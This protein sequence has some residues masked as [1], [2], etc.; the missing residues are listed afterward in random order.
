MLGLSQAWGHRVSAVAVGGLLAGMAVAAGDDRA[1]DESRTERTGCQDEFRLVSSGADDDVAGHYHQVAD[2]FYR[3]GGLGDEFGYAKPPMI[4]RM[5]PSNMLTILAAIGHYPLPTW[6]SAME[7]IRNI[8]GRSGV[9]EFV[10]SGSFCVAC[11]SHATGRTMQESIF[12]HVFGHNSFGSNSRVRR[13]IDHSPMHDSYSLG[14][15]MDQLYQ[16][17]DGG[18]VDAWYAALSTLQHG[19]DSIRG[20]HQGP[21]FFDQRTR[22]QEGRRLAWPAFP[23]RSLLAFGV[24]ALPASTPEWKRGMARRFE[25]MSRYI[26]FVPST[27]VSNEGLATIS[28]DLFA[29]YG[30]GASVGAG[31]ALNFGHALTVAYGGRQRVDIT[32]P[33]WLGHE[34]WLAFRRQV[35]ARESVRDL[36]VRERDRIFAREMHKMASE[37]L[38]PEI[39]HATLDQA[40]VDE[41]MLGLVRPVPRDEWEPLDGK[42]QENPHQWIVTSMS[43]KDVI[44]AIVSSV[45]LDYKIPDIV[46]LSGEA[47]GGGSVALQQEIHGG[48]PL[49][50]DMTFKTL[51]VLA[52]QI[53]ERPVLIEALFKAPATAGLVLGE[54]DQANGSPQLVRAKV[55]VDPRGQVQAWVRSEDGQGWVASEDLSA[56]G[57]RVVDQFVANQAGRFG[58]GVV[59][60]ENRRDDVLAMKVV[61]RTIPGGLGVMAEVP[62]FATAL[63]K[64]EQYLRD[65]VRER[66]RLL[67]EGK[68]RARAVDGGF[69][70]GSPF[71][72]VPWFVLD[73]SVP[74]QGEEG[75][76]PVFVAHAPQVISGLAE[77]RADGSR[78]EALLLARGGGPGRERL[79]RLPGGRPGGRFWG[80]DP[81]ASGEGKKG[82]PEEDEGGRR[83]GDPSGGGERGEPGSGG[84][85]DPEEVVISFEELAE[86]LELELPNR[87]DRAGQNLQNRDEIWSGSRRYPDGEKRW[88]RMYDEVVEGGRPAFEDWWRVHR[89]GQPIPVDPD[90]DILFDFGLGTLTPERIRVRDRRPIVVSQGRAVFVRIMDQS[91]SMHGEPQ[92]RVKRFLRNVEILLRKQYP[93]VDMVNIGFNSAEALVLTDEQFFGNFM[94]GGTDYSLGFKKGLEV[95]DM[96]KYRGWDR[97]SIVA[98]DFEDL[99]SGGQGPPM[100]LIETFLE[101]HNW[102]GAVDVGGTGG[103]YAFKRVMAELGSRKEWFD[104][105]QLSRD[106]GG[107]LEVLRKFFGTPRAKK[108]GG[109][110]P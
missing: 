69:S 74:P 3:P 75:G 63:A 106:A 108:S 84:G 90:P 109:G 11:F 99:S 97:Y 59:A 12:H 6:M 100:D 4:A 82:P 78:V 64:Y 58:A 8:S 72:E 95:L 5:V 9:L 18:E 62:F 88:D 81:E 45:R 23:S 34:E 55:R 48:V 66:L 56:R 39:L 92:E 76:A 44:Q 2:E 1:D 83:D 107:Q 102:A 101:Q 21:E 7:I 77:M 79:G 38:D 24:A 14:Q 93:Q 105:A 70:L 37:L 28:Q 16:S 13:T 68:L 73:R 94:N 89:P 32:N 50:R 10:H 104:F 46:L 35:H 71:P 42:S 87:R 52:R 20:T 25:R 19:I 41:H 26:A 31:R 60:H 33:Y 80:P 30:G 47:E 36:P 57:Q 15:Y 17:V 110:S 103:E 86:V 29:A 40:F 43:A 96:E 49:R 27:K 85:A 67:R 53:F 22:V 54:Q 51:A 61:E 98:G 65:A 91:G